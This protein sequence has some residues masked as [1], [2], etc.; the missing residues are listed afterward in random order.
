[1]TLKQEIAL[2]SLIALNAIKLIN[3]LGTMQE[4]MVIGMIIAMEEHMK[5]LI[6]TVRKFLMMPS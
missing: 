4:V 6:A 2:I 5:S 3:A 1:M